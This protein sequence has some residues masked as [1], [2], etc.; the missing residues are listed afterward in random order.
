MRR[1]DFITLLGGVAAWPLG[2]RAQQPTV[3]VIGFLSARSPSE[4]AN[5]VAAFRQ[6]LNEAGYIE[7]QNVHVAFRW[8]EGRYDQL[9]V[10]AA[11]LVQI[12]VAVIAAGGGTVSA[13]AAKAVT[14][15]IPVVF[16]SDDDPVKVGLV[17][18]LNRPGG[19]VTGIYQ[20]TTGLEAKRLGLLHE[21]VPN[22]TMI[23]VLVNPKYPDAETQVRELQDAA[24]T[25]GLQVHI[26]KASSEGDF[27]TAFASLIQQRAGALL[28]ASDPFLF[29]RRDQ[30]VALAARDAV[31]AIYQFRESAAS[32]GLMSY[33]TRITDSYRQVGVYTGRILRGAKP[34]DLPV[35]QSTKFEFVLNLKTARTLGLTVP[36]TL[37]ALADEVIE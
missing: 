16:I 21:L 13:R 5:V 7:G 18:S 17:A 22:A 36:P 14:A 1:R 19:N 4:S 24:R 32:G 10:L 35:V 20:L 30:L 11:E 9:P 26:L 3:P 33:G 34:A 12:R 8:A 6:G 25:L 15:M 28:V 2:A 31:P 23:A 29:S 27:D 37:L